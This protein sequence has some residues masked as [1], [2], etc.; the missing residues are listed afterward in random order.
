MY[1][2]QG[3]IPFKTTS[4]TQGVNFTAGLNIIRTSLFT[5][6]LMRFQEKALQMKTHLDKQYF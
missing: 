4:F 3:L 5:V 2:D 6:L 1:H